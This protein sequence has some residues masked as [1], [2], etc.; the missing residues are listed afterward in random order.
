MSTAVLV[1][2]GEGT[3]F[4]D[5]DALAFGEEDVTSLGNADG[6]LERT[7]WSVDAF[8]HPASTRS[9]ATVVNL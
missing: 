8:V 4:G 6:L 9:I 5:E 1:V 7:G 3:S 2:V